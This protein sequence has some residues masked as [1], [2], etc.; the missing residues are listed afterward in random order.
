M[1]NQLMVMVLALGVAHCGAQTTDPPEPPLEGL[2]GAPAPGSGWSTPTPPV[3]RF[4]GQKTPIV[5][6][7]GAVSDTLLDT[8]DG[9]TYTTG[10]FTG[11][12]VIGKTL[13]VSKGEDDVFISKRNANEVVEWALSVGSVAEESAPH[14][15]LSSGHVNVIAMTTGN[16]DCGAGPLPNYA[17]T[18]TWIMCEFDPTDG[19][20]V[21]GASFPVRDGP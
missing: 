4:G 20:L 13:L 14:L 6:P 8:L 2:E 21:A 10:T 9:A 5:M 12:I 7:G 1:K 3:Q 19:A 16:V 15:A 11:D 17:N 18:G